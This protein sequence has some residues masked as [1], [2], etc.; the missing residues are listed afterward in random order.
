VFVPGLAEKL[1]PRKIGEEP[2]LLDAVREQLGAGSRPTSAGSTPSGSRC[3]SRSARA[4]RAPVLS[5]PRLDVDGSRPRVPSFYALEALRAAEG[6]LPGFDELSRRAET[7]GEARLGWPAPARA[8]DAIDAA[9]FDLARLATLEGDD[10]A[11]R[12]AARYLLGANPHL[13]RALRFRARRWKVAGWTTADGLVKP[14]DAG[15]RRSRRT[16]SV[17][18]AIRRPRSSITRCARTASSS[19]RC[20]SSRRARSPRRSRSSIRSSAAR[21]CTRC[22]SSCSVRCATRTCCP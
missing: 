18:A 2:I 5:Y 1:F 10:D 13:G 19:R 17:R 20:G 21:S 6:V 22:S 8:A 3:G 12:G 7:F 9:E 14:N 16:R 15:R 11:S 4:A